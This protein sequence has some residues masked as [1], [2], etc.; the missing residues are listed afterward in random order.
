MKCEKCLKNEATV[1]YRE[2]IN[3]K[4]TKM[5]LCSKCAGEKEKES[6]LPF[7]ELS[8]DGLFGNV[9][10]TLGAHKPYVTERKRCSLC[11]C[12]YA[13]IEKMGKVG[14]HKCYESF[15]AEMANTL[16]RLHGNA[17]STYH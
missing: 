6:S 9:F 2:I 3:G 15:S 11:G 16:K 13:D 4:E 14:C 7:G 1:F 8:F 5:H 10:S 12:T 17:T